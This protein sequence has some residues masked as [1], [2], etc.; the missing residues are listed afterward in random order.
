MENY[1]RYGGRGIFVCDRWRYGEG[2]T[3]GFECFLADMGRRPSPSLSIDRIDN[4]GPYS[5]KI[6][7]GQ[8]PKSRVQT[9]VHEPPEM[10]DVEELPEELTWA[11]NAPDLEHPVLPKPVKKYRLWELICR[12]LELVERIDC[13]E[14][15][16]TREGSCLTEAQ[17]K[18]RD[19]AAQ[20]AQTLQLLEMHE[21]DIVALIKKK[22]KPK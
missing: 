19:L 4:N 7:V 15:I 6:A 2:G 22:K 21:R 18:D 5:R 11:L 16:R 3:S 17:Q 12:Q 1:P 10:S 14:R 20:T 9:G 13:W 8:R